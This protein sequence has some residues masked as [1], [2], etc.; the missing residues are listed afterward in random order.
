MSKIAC[1]LVTYHPL[2]LRVVATNDELEMVNKRSA[3]HSDKRKMVPT[4]RFLN[5]SKWEGIDKG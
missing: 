4:V 1:H 2:S 3:K 5:P